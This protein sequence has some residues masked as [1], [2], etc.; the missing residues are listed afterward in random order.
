MDIRDKSTELDKSKKFATVVYR[1]IDGKAV[2]TPV[3]AGQSDLTHT[4]ILAGLKDGD[5]VVVGPYKILDNLKHD[6]KLKDEREAEK[7]KNKKEKVKDK[8]DSND[9]NATADK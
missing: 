4:I 8:K 7:E 3:R 1:F 9:I 6:Q 2:A 5:K